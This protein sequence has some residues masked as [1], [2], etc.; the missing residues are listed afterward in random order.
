MSAY[1][2]IDNGLGGLLQIQS[3]YRKLIAVE[4]HIHLFRFFLRWPHFLSKI[5]EDVFENLIY[6]QVLFNTTIP[7][8]HE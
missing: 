5:V 3:K 2:F 1:V 6:K 7:P 8:K 4:R